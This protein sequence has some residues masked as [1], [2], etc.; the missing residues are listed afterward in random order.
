M[1]LSNPG[2]EDCPLVGDEEYSRGMQYCRIG[3]KI[4]KI[5]KNLKTLYNLL[6]NGKI[7]PLFFKLALYLEK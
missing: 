7:C 2:I 5:D 1:L 4:F 6:K 3:T